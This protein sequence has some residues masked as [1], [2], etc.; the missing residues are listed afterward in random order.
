LPF[1][2]GLRIGNRIR[3]TPNSVQLLKSTEKTQTHITSP[4]SQNAEYLVG[5]GTNPVTT[6]TLHTIKNPEITQNID[7]FMDHQLVKIKPQLPRLNLQ[8]FMECGISQPE[9]NKHLKQI[10]QIDP[11]N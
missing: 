9:I 11:P 8:A 7:G 6:F 1:A 2:S 5:E 3:F 10:S 4:A